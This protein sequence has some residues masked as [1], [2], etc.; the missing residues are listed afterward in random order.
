MRLP[1]PTNNETAIIHRRLKPMS[2]DEKQ[3]LNII[4]REVE[5]LKKEFQ[6]LKILKEIADEIKHFRKYLLGG[7]QRFE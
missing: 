1:Y 2:Q 7:T 4:Q 5:R 3:Q 6:E